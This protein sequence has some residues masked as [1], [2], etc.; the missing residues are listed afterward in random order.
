M[1]RVSKGGMLGRPAALIAWHV[2]CKSFACIASHASTLA[3][4]R[5]LDLVYDFVRL[6]ARRRLDVPLAPEERAVHAGLAL[7]LAGERPD[8]DRR[9]WPRVRERRAVRFSH[10]RGFGSG[11]LRDLSAGGLSVATSAPPDVGSEVLLH[12]DDGSSGLRYVLPV[13]V[14]WRASGPDAGFG[15]TFAGAPQR[16]PIAGERARSFT[17]SGVFLTARAGATERPESGTG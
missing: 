4:K 7:L 9:A 14:C 6:D 1:V 10:S 17:P 2:G 8:A 12:V 15:A 16:L 5:F 11:R 13:R 3:M